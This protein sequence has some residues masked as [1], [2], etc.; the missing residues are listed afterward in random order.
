MPH[1]KENS[2]AGSSVDGSLYCHVAWISDAGCSRLCKVGGIS[3]SNSP[4]AL[5]CA[6]LGLSSLCVA[7]PVA[8]TL[9]GPATAK[10]GSTVIMT[11]SAAG[12]TDTGSA[13]VQWHVGLPAG[14]TATAA[15]GAADSANKTLTCT[16]DASTCI[17]AGLNISVIP[18]GAV[19]VYTIKVPAVAPIGSVSF[20]LTG[21]IAVSSTVAGVVSAVPTSLGTPYALTIQKIPQD[22]NGDGKVDATDVFLMAAQSVGS[23]PCTDDQNADA[24]CN[25]YDVLIVVLK[26]L[27]LI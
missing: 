16:A 4:G 1:D 26:A 24:V 27:G 23:A 25:P 5:I 7:Q 14:Y 6:F 11:L 2:D 12:G 19:A 8:F 18:N 22:L 21:I 3:M 15:L 20:P 10:P 13:A 17:A 9:T